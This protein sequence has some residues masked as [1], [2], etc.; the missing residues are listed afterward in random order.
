MKTDNLEFFPDLFPVSTS[1]Y[2]ET[3]QIN[4]KIKGVILL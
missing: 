2:T 4:T 3:T 1:E